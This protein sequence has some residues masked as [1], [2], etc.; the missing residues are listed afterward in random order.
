[1]LI[2]P[3]LFDT[4]SQVHIPA[5]ERDG[6]QGVHDLGIC[7]DCLSRASL[8]NLLFA[9]RPAR[10]QHRFYSGDSDERA[11]AEV[12]SGQQGIY[13]V[14]LR[15]PMAPIGADKTLQ[16]YERLVVPSQVAGTNQQEEEEE[17]LDKLD[18]MYSKLLK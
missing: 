5:V 4:H 11:D 15:A 2:I 10:R 18:C 8:V 9:R 14:V 1:M 7:D 3:K 6:T 13:N 16:T 12:A 17:E